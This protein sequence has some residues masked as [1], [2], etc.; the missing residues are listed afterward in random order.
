[1]KPSDEAMKIANGIA[2]MYHPVL[3]DDLVKA[4]AVMIDDHTAPLR[5]EVEALRARVAWKRVVD[6]SPPMMPCDLPRMPR[7]DEWFLFWY[8]GQVR[9]VYAVDH[10]SVVRCWA[11]DGIINVSLSPDDFWQPLPQPP[12]E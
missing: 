1:M 11:E 2:Q 3:P 9:R 6:E 8:D 7:P 4:A 10:H 5:A 12:S